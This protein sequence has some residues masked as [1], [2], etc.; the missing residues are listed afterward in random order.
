MKISEKE[1]EDY[2]FSKLNENKGQELSDAGL[3]S[4]GESNKVGGDKKNYYR[5]LHLGDYGRCDIL[6]I[7]LFKKM[8]DN[9]CEAYSY[10]LV[11]LKEGEIN[12]EIIFQCLKYIKA[13]EYDLKLSSLGLGVS[14]ITIIGSSITKDVYDTINLCFPDTSIVHVFIYEISLGRGISFKYILDSHFYEQRCCDD[15]SDFIN[16]CDGSCSISLSAGCKIGEKIRE[17]KEISGIVDRD[18]SWLISRTQKDGQ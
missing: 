3:S 13:I 12:K 1:L 14:E 17:L 18:F 10:H 8:D 5:Q 7:E 11:E 2:I 15:P 9:T 16:G 4:F 6:G